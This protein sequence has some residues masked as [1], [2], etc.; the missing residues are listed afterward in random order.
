MVPVA[1]PLSPVSKMEL[2]ALIQIQTLESVLT[3]TDY[4]TLSGFRYILLVK[5]YDL[6][7]VVGMRVQHIVQSLSRL[8]NSK[9]TSGMILYVLPTWLLAS[10]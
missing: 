9:E 4:S 8:S 7:L 1:R 6:E 10:W 5:T 3:L 2:L